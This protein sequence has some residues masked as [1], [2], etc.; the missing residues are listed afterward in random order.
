MLSYNMDDREQL[1]L[2]EYLYRCIKNDIL[3]GNLVPD[4]RLPSKRPLA[5]HLGISLITV[6]GAYSQLQAEGY[7]YALP[8]KGYYVCNLPSNLPRR[9]QAALNPLYNNAVHTNREDEEPPSNLVADFSHPTLSAN[10][11]A[12]QLWGK[13]LRSTLAHEPQSE[14]FCSQPAQG[15]KRLRNAIACYLSQARGMSVSPD[16]VVIG[17]GAQM[18]YTYVSLLFGANAP[19]ALENPGY[20]RLK[21]IYSALGH[22]I[23][24]IDLDGDGIGVFQLERSRAQIAHVMPSHQFP[25]GRVMSISRRYELLGWASRRPERYIVE[26]DYDWEFR[27]AGKP[28]PSLESIDVKS[29]V[30]Y[31]STFSKSLSSALRVAFAILPPALM[32][33][34]ESKL[35]FLTST[36]S[37]LDQIALARLIES[38]DYEKHL[39]RYRKQSRATRDALV[40]A[41]GRSRLADR[42]AIEEKDS[43]L[44][45]VLNIESSRS[46]E[47]IAR[48]ARKDGVILAPL[49]NYLLCA[50]D[51]ASKRDN[52]S[53]VMQYDGLDLQNVQAVVKSIERAAG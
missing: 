49:S 7:I 48:L 50:H 42:I 46:E 34:F 9:N 44:H 16:C 17:A 20:P 40:N 41:L 3:D 52:A 30:I 51:P 4:D 22:D 18:L 38:G 10:S 19:I 33:R 32:E 15:S 31:I 13:T 24:P 43:G 53:F 25:T 2:Y 6:E 14:L 21:G 27:F 12:A 45:F 39:N 47:E 23:C 36:V 37:A 1:P 35:G 28:I 11:P 8:R 26:D 5:E 29:K